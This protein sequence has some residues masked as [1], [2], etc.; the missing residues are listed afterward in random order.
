MAHLHVLVPWMGW[1]KGQAQW[2]CGYVWSSTK[3]QRS[4]SLC[5]VYQADWSP[6]T[7]AQSSQ[8]QF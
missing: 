4:S 5:S 8:E 6:Y 2:D 1:L 7:V 3:C